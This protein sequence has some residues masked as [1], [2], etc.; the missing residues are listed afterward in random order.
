[1]TYQIEMLWNCTHCKSQNKGRFKD[2]HYC[3]NP[4]DGTEEFYMP[5]DT[6]RQ[7][8]IT[9]LFLLN[10]ATAGEDWECK[11]CKSH[12]RRDN[13]E[14]A[15]C[16]AEQRQDKLTSSNTPEPESFAQADAPTSYSFTNKSKQSKKY[17]LFSLA[18][19][20]FALLIWLFWPKTVNAT[21]SDLYFLHVVHI[22]RYQLVNQEGFNFP[23]GAEEVDFVGERVH[24]HEK[25]S[26]GFRTEHYSEQVRDGEK[27]TNTPKSCQD[28]CSSN[29]NGFA[30]CRTVCTG[31]ERHC[32][33]KYKTVKRTRQIEK[34]KDVP[35]YR[36]YYY[37]K[38]WAWKHH[39][40]VHTTGSSP[41][42]P[43]RE[44]LAL[45]KNCVGKERERYS[46]SATYTITFSDNHDFWKY[47]TSSLEE[48]KKYKLND[49]YLITVSAGQ[50]IKME[51][52]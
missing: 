30:T 36:P 49:K 39:R 17:W 15:Q 13:G 9:D 18:V 42:W 46:Q 43:T 14:C 34:F 52:K 37:W 50:I 32:T 16:G 1:M 3:G 41:H 4:L 27:C 20:P 21:V 45:N 11:Y 23:L 35:Q 29:K 10:Q 8:Q 31:G 24:H 6:S 25:I 40:N 38:E 26:D 22:E 33:P 7:N 5:S 48:Y 44:Q 2:C 51:K 28:K 12:Q 47:N 19:I